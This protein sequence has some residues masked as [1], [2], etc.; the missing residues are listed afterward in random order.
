MK[1][2]DIS[3]KRT[4]KN[5][6]FLSDICLDKYDL[7]TY[8]ILTLFQINALEDGDLAKTIKRTRITKSVYH[9]I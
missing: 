2:K 5:L 1:K 4:G 9:Q 6:I 8:G 3:Q 7:P